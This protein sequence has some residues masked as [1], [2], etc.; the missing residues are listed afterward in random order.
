GLTGAAGLV[1]VTPVAAAEAWGTPAIREF[2][3]FVTALLT[4]VNWAA[5]AAGAVCA[6]TL[7]NG[8]SG[9]VAATGTAILETACWKGLATAPLAFVIAA[10]VG[11]AAAFGSQPA[12]LAAACP[13]FCAFLRWNMDPRFEIAAAAFET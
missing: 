3:V 10:G 4:G 7:A 13:A 8:F 2:G 6:G 12:T 5:F 1:V 11:I 9:F